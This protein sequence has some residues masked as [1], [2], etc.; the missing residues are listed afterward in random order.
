[1]YINFRTQVVS[2]LGNRSLFRPSAFNLRRERV[3]TNVRLGSGIKISHDWDLALRDPGSRRAA[4]RIRA[5][6]FE[7]SRFGLARAGRGLRAAP[8][9]LSARRR[10]RLR[11]A[12][13]VFSSG[14]GSTPRAARR[15]KPGPVKTFNQSN[16]ELRPQSAA[17]RCSQILSSTYFRHV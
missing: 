3:W 13:F 6:P 15:V 16:R 5:P 17:R 1:M 14:R 9:R 4:T 8:E 7:V 2:S 11:K 12:R 10:T